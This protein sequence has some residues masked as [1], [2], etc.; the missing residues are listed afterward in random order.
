VNFK[1]FTLLVYTTF[2]VH[3]LGWERNMSLFY[4]DK[5]CFHPKLWTKK[6]FWTGRGGED[7]P[8][9]NSILWGLDVGGKFWL[10]VEMLLAARLIS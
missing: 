1:Y 6:K 4:M 7:S 5:F 8:S 2:I 9:P 10:P 3:S